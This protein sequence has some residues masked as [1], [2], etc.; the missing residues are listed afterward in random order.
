MILPVT[1]PHPRMGK[2][3]LAWRGQSFV[4]PYIHRQGTGGPT[5]LFVHGL[6]GAKENFYV[7]LQCKAMATFTIVM[8]DLPGLSPFHPE[9]GLDVS[10]LAELTHRFAEKVIAGSYWVRRSLRLSS[11][12][13]ITATRDAL[14]YCHAINL[15]RLL[16]LRSGGRSNLTVDG[17]ARFR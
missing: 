14:I 6:G 1:T 4:L 10:G 15:R 11:S 8:F 3:D 16:L 12:L 7:A 2:L 5:V 17:G 13:I 9:A